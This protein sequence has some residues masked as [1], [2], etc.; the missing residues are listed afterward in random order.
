MKLGKVI[1]GAVLWFVV[2]GLGYWLYTIIQDPVQ[3]EKDYVVRRSATIER[4]EDIRVA[5]SYY[6]KSKGK[7]AGSF[8]ELIG[9]IKNDLI[10]EIVVNGNADD[11][12]IVT[13]YDTL[14]YYIK[15]KIQFNR[16]PK[17][18]DLRKIPFSE[19]EDFGMQADILT[20]QRVEVP[21]YEVL[22]PKEQFL[23]NLDQE[24]WG[25]KEDLVMGSVI[26]A[27]D[28]GSWE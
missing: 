13:T 28:R 8:D 17:P 7:Y 25:I 11:T 26:Q 5:Q 21:V 22:A 4:M 1:V 9:S 2:A 16:T 12:S 18:D 14:K 10:T 15:D 3:F 24:F 6:L 20:L 19:G 23:K 27:T